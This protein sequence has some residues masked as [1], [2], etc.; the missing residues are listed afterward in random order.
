MRNTEKENFSMLLD[1]IMKEI[2][3]IIDNTE[4][5]YFLF[6]NFNFM[7]E[8]GRMANIRTSAAIFFDKIQ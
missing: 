2:I 5:E 1:H 8:N 3:E 4:K 6:P 7:K